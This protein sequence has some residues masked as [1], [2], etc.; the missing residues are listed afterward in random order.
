M[1]TKILAL[2]LGCTLLALGLQTLFFQNSASSLIF[3]LERESA[4]K[5]LGRMQDELYTW[6]KSYENDLIKLYNQTDLMRDLAADPDRAAVMDKNSRIA[7]T[8]MQSVFD[9]NQYVTALYLYS[10]DHRLVS[11]S[12]IAS[13]PRYNYPEDIYTDP[14]ASRAD[15]VSDYVKGDDRVMLVTSSYNKSRGQTIL[16]LVL[17]LYTNNVRTKI[18][19]VVCDVDPKGFSRIVEKYVYSDRQVVWLQPEGDDPVLVYGAH[20]AVGPAFARAVTGIR[21]GTWSDNDVRQIRNSVFLSDS[22][23]KYRLTAWSLVPQELLEESQN[24]LTRNMLV[25]ALLVVLVAVVSAFLITRSLTTPLTGI[26]QSLGRIKDGQTDLRLTDLRS[27]EIGVLGR[28]INEM[29]DRIQELIAWEYH[30]EL[31]LKQAEYKAL[32]AQVNPHFLYN[33]LDTMGS[34][35][36][37]Q[38]APTVATLCRAMSNLF[39]YSLDMKDPLS[40]LGNEIVHLKNYLYV[41]NVRT[42]NSLDVDIAIDRDLLDERVPRLCLQPLV[43]NSINHGLKNKRGAKKIRI[44]AQADGETLTLTVHDNGVGMDADEINRQLTA[45]PTRVTEKNGSIGLV[46]IHARIVLLFG[47]AFGIRI[48]SVSGEGTTVGF[49]VPRSHAPGGSP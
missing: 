9:P 7:Y 10:M 11:Y 30:A 15:V 49:S 3:R 39:R 31:Q 23:M 44:S 28:S 12:R 37:A 48:N 14:T 40:A 36:T 47:A 18:G 41:M 34:I 24:V 16:R 26:V 21:A 32:Q 1:R 20:D 2:C 42:G 27:D 43:E 8:M 6:I 13:T 46:N 33:T 45:D 22:Q 5:S 29:L 38:N 19:F 17:K 25:I 35:A 4:R